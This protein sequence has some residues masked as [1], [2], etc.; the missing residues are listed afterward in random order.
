MNDNIYYGLNFNDPGIG[1]ESCIYRDST[2]FEHLRKT[3][4]LTD[5]TYRL[6]TDPPTLHPTHFKKQYGSLIEKLNL[7]IMHLTQ[8]RKKIGTQEIIPVKTIKKILYRLKCVV[9]VFKEDLNPLRS[10]AENVQTIKDD[11]Q[12]IEDA[13]ALLTT[14]V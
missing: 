13:L 9:A 5:V 12:F 2:I 3:V 7:Q 1:L 11:I 6:Y 14:E 10:I 8:L 4:S